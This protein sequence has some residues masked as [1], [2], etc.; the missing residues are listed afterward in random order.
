MVT[1]ENLK[2]FVFCTSVKKKPALSAC[3]AVNASFCSGVNEWIDA[4]S[5]IR[6]WFSGKPQISLKPEI[7]DFGFRADFGINV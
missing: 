7:F 4:N 6:G 2:T 5:R 1:K 3:S